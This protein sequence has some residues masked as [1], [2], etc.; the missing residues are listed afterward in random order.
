MIIKK[1]RF[2]V[3][4]GLRGVAAVIVMLF[5]YLFMFH[6]QFGYNIDPIIQ[7]RYGFYGVQLFFMISGFVVYFSIIN[8]RS[9]GDFILKRFI[10]LFP[11]YWLCLVITYMFVSA[12]SLSE[13]SSPNLKDAIINLSMLQGIFNIKHI[14]PSYWSLQIELFFYFVIILIFLFKLH[15]YMGFVLVTWLA[16]IFFYNFIFKIPGLGLLF[17]LQ[18]GMYF[19]AG[20]GFYN[21]TR[22]NVH[23]IFNYSIILASLILGLAVQSNS[24]GFWWCIPSIYVVFLLSINNGLNFLNNSFILFLGKISY[25]LYLIHQSIGYVILQ[26]L[27][28]VG[29]CHPIFSI[30]PIIIS[31]TLAWLIT[32]YYETAIN[33]WLLSKLR[34][35]NIS[36]ISF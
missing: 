9:I 3:I 30:V 15:D 32:K 11:T 35:I 8:S 27:K 22:K 20:I 25:P 24:D 19:I 31:V 6:D 14:D 34:N 7:F 5:H 26:N 29:Y 23:I 4:D 33:E 28:K 21:I 18:Y 13:E 17:N 12:Y 16:L 1:N 36:L 10:R 2:V